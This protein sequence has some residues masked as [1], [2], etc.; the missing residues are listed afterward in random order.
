MQARTIRPA[1]TQKLQDVL[2]AQRAVDRK[3]QELV[4]ASTVSADSPLRLPTGG[5]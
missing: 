2:V 5:S 3:A 4:A 1:L